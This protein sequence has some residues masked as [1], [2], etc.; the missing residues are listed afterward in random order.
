MALGVIRNGVS[1]VDDVGAEFIQAFSEGL[2]ALIVG[3]EPIKIR[4]K[5]GPNPT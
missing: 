2:D 3:F 5:I 4:D 1:I